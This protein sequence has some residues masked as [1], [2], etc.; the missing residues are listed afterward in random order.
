[1]QVK[2]RVSVEALTSVLADLVA[3]LKRL[4]QAPAI[5]EAVGLDMPFS[6]LCALF[7]L[8]SSD[9]APSVHE[10]ADRLGLSVAAAGRA[11]DALVRA[12]LVERREDEHDRRVKRITLAE[13]GNRLIAR[14]TAAQTEG[15]RVF[16]GLLTDQERANLH[17]ALTPILARPELQNHKVK[18]TG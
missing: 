18:E 1:V 5:Q 14:L 16:A 3:H 7:I 15:L 4:G 9:H 13:P 12:G 11:V 17:A 8:D 6:Q 10:L 2:R